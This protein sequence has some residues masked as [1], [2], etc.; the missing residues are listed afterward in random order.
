MKRILLVGGGGH[1]RSVIDTIIKADVYEEIGIIDDNTCDYNGVLTIG[2]DDD[3]GRLHDEGW[4]D[5]FVTVGSIGDTTIRRRL[6]DMLREEGFNIPVIIDPTAVIA[7]D[8]VIEDGVFVGKGAIINSACKIGKCAII[9]TRAV[10]EHDC[11]VGA[12]AH[13]STGSILCGQTRVGDNTHIGAGSVVRQS[14]NIG[15]DSLIG[16][17]SVVVKDIS[18][19]VNGF[20]NPFKVR[21]SI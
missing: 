2:N 14:V 11:L 7:E 1:C 6:Y 16:V 4:T 20:G 3:I 10:I 15:N 9:N 8:V 17:G 19:H 13:I 18:D 5:A 12:F 21:Q